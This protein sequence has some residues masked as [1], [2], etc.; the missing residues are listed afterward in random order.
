MDEI[1]EHAL[2]LTSQEQ[3]N[4]KSIWSTEKG[5]FRQCTSILGL[6]KQN[7][8]FYSR[9]L[10]ILPRQSPIS[11]PSTVVIRQSPTTRDFT[12]YI[13]LLQCV[14]RCG[15]IYLVTNEVLKYPNLFSERELS[16]PLGTKMWCYWRRSKQYHSIV[17]PLRPEATLINY[18]TI[19][20]YITDLTIFEKQ[21]IVRQE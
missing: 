20:V 8:I 14:I 19:T 5:Y 15:N 4:R 18:N 17:S 16:R 21:M 12:P 10:P 2:C 11:E 13:K 1:E 3:K 6:Q 7:F 9:R